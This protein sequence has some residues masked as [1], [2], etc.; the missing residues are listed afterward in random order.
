MSILQK[1]LDDV[2]GGEPK[3]LDHREQVYIAGNQEDGRGKGLE[4]PSDR[5]GKERHGENSTR[6]CVPDQLRFFNKVQRRQG[7]QLSKQL[8]ED[9]KFL[10]EYI[11]DDEYESFLN[12]YELVPFSSQ[13]TLE[14]NAALVSQYKGRHIFPTIY[15]LKMEIERHDEIHTQRDRETPR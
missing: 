11:W 1:P 9:L 13:D 5:S 2:L 4:Q 10:I 12:T 7:M 15:S 6:H 8:T 14:E 3:T